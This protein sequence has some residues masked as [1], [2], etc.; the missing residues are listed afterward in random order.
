[1]LFAA[2]S[3]IKKIT[4]YF[5]PSCATKPVGKTPD[6]TKA[7]MVVTSEVKIPEPIA[8]IRKTLPSVSIFTAKKA[9]TACRY[10]WE[11]AVAFLRSQGE[12][13]GVT[14]DEIE[15]PDPQPNLRVG[16]VVNATKIWNGMTKNSL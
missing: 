8:Q 2:V 9:L 16:A 3:C 15:G 13:V 10:D 7:D 5:G 12:S 14:D 4:L 6:G 1:M 11:A